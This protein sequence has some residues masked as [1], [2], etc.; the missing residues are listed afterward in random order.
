MQPREALPI[1]EGFKAIG[2]THNKRI[3]NET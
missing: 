1:L 2:Q 3:P